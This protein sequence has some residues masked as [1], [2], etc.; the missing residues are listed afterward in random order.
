MTTLTEQAIGS[1]QLHAADNVVVATNDLATGT[2]AGTLTVREPVPR[3]H[4]MA[5]AAIAVGEP[6]R[7]YNQIIGFATE[8]IPRGSHVH[9]HNTEFRAFERDYAFGA[10]VVPTAI[11]PDS[12]RA[13]FQGIVRADGS[14]AT[15]N[16]IGIITSVNCSATTAKFIAQAIRASGALEDYPN[17]TAWSR[18]STG[19]AA[20]WRGTAKASMSCSGRSPATRRTQTSPAS[21]C[22]AWAARSTRSPA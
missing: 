18:W 8:A 15:R 10:D 11:V 17:I 7:K 1:V 13:T 21:C 14:V 12:E 22:W 19:W 4:K 9:T 5:V 16:Y 6:I 20:G 2:S 3:G